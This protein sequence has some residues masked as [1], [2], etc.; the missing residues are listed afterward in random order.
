MGAKFKPNEFENVRG[1]AYWLL[2]QYYPYLKN[3][4]D[5]LC[6]AM[7]CAFLAGESAYKSK[8]KSK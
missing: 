3:E 1:V 8:S 2:H 5:L 4:T 7:T 6:V